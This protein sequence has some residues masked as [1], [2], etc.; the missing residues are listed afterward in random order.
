MERTRAITVRLEPR[1]CTV[2][3]KGTREAYNVPWGAVLD[4][5]RKIG[6]RE[7][8]AARNAARGR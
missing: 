6:L 1:F 8:I 7:K 5:G 3:V 4:L 2:G